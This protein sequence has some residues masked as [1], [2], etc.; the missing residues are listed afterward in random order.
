[1]GSLI[2]LLREA[3]QP[4]HKLLEA[5]TRLPQSL[6]S[7]EDLQR[8]LVTFLG[9]YTALDPVLHVASQGVVPAEVADRPWRSR[10]LRQDL[11][12]M[13]LDDE[14][15][16]EIPVCV[17]IPAKLTC[18]PAWGIHYVVEGSALGGKVISSHMK[19]HS[20]LTGWDGKL[21]FFNMYGSDTTSRW[22]RFMAEL[23]N[24]NTSQAEQMQIVKGA[25]MAFS[26]LTDWFQENQKSALVV[27]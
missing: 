13:G 9:Y 26:T 20:S 21:R 17:R 5:V 14:D 18:Y 11:I 15:L 2:T 27:D 19:N 6:E 22:K 10:V 8:V 16:A 4:Q 25:Q 1:M 24:L 7:A 3:T 23:D 12:A